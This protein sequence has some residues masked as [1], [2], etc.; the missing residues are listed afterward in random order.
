MTPNLSQ[1]SYRPNRALPS[2]KRETNGGEDLKKWRQ[3]GAETEDT[4]S[5]NLRVVA[6]S[7]RLSM[8]PPSLPPASVPPFSLQTPISSVYGEKNSMQCR[9]GLC[10]LL[11][12]NGDLYPL[13]PINHTHFMLDLLL[14]NFNQII[15]NLTVTSPIESPQVWK[16]SDSNLRSLKNS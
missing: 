10:F 9:P 14:P 15:Q 8:S 16:R 3:R 12:C 13:S 6:T 2:N 7:P 11:Q 4:T 1:F 5:S